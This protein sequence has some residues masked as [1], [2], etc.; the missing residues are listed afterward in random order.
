[1]RP[2]PPA[3]GQNPYF[4]RSKVAND[5]KAAGVVPIALHQSS[6][7]VLLG[8]ERGKTGPKGKASGPCVCAE[9]MGLSD[10]W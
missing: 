3:P 8:C 4:T 1:M 6:I 2:A 5:Y 7:V 10:T 9:V